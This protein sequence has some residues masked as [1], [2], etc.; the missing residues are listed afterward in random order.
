MAGKGLIFHQNIFKR[1]KES[2]VFIISLFIIIVGLAFVAYYHE[3]F[4][5]LIPGYYEFDKYRD[6]LSKRNDLVD[7][8]NFLVSENV[9]LVEKLNSLGSSSAEFEKKRL[10]SV[11][12]S[13][14]LNKTT[15]N[16]K[17]LS[18]LNNQLSELRLISKLNEY[19]SVLSTVDELSLKARNAELQIS[20]ARIM[21]YSYRTK[22]AKF[23]ECISSVNKTSNSFSV[24]AER[25]TA[26]KI[27]SCLDILT[28]A[29]NSVN[30]IE[31]EIKK[32]LPLTTNYIK[33]LSDFW[34]NSY[35]F[36]KYLAAEKITEAEKY[37]N[38]AAQYKRI[39]TELDLDNINEEFNDVYLDDLI[40]D[41]VV[42]IEKT[43]AKQIE[44]DKFFSDNLE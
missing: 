3:V 14:N 25:A 23:N 5:S 10:I 18:S 36:H 20:D 27:D 22:E 38:Q 31:N 29:Q 19:I 13:G 21:Y 7:E 39:I 35:N 37:N 34:T 44:A 9:Q 1:I 6:V 8:N 26:K 17:K 2:F 15:K 28:E 4:L 32:E 12:I 42:L 40:N 43:D 24:T 33:N 41:A 11:D 16:L 30:D